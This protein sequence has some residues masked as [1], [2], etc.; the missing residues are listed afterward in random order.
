MDKAVIVVMA[1]F[2]TIG[3]LDKAFFNGRFGYGK[4]FEKGLSVGD[5]SGAVIGGVL[6]VHWVRSCVVSGIDLGG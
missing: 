1:L 4:E 5:C 2:M 6:F 3:A